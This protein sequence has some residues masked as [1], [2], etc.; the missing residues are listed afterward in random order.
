MVQIFGSGAILRES[1]RAQE[2]LEQQFGV[3]S[4][5]YSVTS[6][7]ELLADA[8]DCQRHNRLHPDDAPR[9]PFVRQTL[10]G[11]RGP[12]VTASDYVSAL[13][14]SIAPWI[15]RRYTA[16]GTDGFGRSEA[17]AELRRFFEV[18]AEHIALAAL[19][20][21]ALDGEYPKKKL[22]AAIKTLGIDPD[23]PNPVTV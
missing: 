18:D 3:G 15:E 9:V 21:L 14:L 11:R 5:V 10:E 7:K 17:R 6:Y 22:S 12:V 2:I 8:R 16:L 20:S 13:P 1:L 23:S 19:E 4:D